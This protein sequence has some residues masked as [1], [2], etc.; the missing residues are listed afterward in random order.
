MNGKTA[1]LPETE[2]RLGTGEPICSHIVRRTGNESA[3]A[4]VMR[5]RVEGTEIEALCGHK[6]VPSRDPKAHPLCEVCKQVFDL[7]GDMGD[8]PRGM[9][10][11]GLPS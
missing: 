2:E 10:P 5:A 1:L 7:Y 4:M 11:T 3:A 6:W 9:D 8:V